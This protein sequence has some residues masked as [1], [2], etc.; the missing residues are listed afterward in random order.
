M[1]NFLFANY[2]YLCGLKNETVLNCHQL[3]LKVADGGMGAD[4]K[5]ISI[6]RL[7]KK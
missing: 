3:K 6:S 1:G 5:A 7:S 4:T 2:Y